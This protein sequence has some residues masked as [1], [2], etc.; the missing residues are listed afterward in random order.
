M[1]SDTD[2]SNNGNRGIVLNQLKRNEFIYT[3]IFILFYSSQNTIMFIWSFLLS[4]KCFSHL[5]FLKW[6]YLCPLECD[7]SF[8]CID[9]P[10]LISNKCNPVHI[11]FN[12]IV[13][14]FCWFSFLPRSQNILHEN[15]NIRFSMLINDSENQNKC[16]ID[17]KRT[18]P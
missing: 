9:M 10:K 11:L 13:Y 12:A 17:S 15:Q 2:L 16:I 18:K 4:K 5:L 14:F 7:V 1:Y 3:F 8:T 6:I